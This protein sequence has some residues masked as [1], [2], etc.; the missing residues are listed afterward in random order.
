MEPNIIR[1]DE[2]VG[3]LMAHRY[4]IMLDYVSKNHCDNILEI[5]TNTGHTA[6]ELIKHSLNKQVNYH[7]IDLFAEGWTDDIERNE[8]SI[9][10]DSKKDV[11]CWL[12][13]CSENVFLHQGT[14]KEKHKEI[15][16]LKIKF[17]LIFIDGGHSY[18][19]VRDDFFMYLPLLKENGVIFFDDYTTEFSFPPSNKIPFGVKPFIDDLIRFGQYDI[20]IV[21]DYVDEYRGHLY[22]IV[23]VKKTKSLE[24]ITLTTSNNTKLLNDFFLPTLPKD[25][26]DVIIYNVN[27]LNLEKNNW[28]MYTENIDNNNFEILGRF[29]T[30]MN[31]K[32]HFQRKYIH[33]N[34]GKKIMF[35]D[36]DVIFFNPFK[37]EILSYLDEYD[38]VLQDNNLDYNGGVWAMNCNQN[39]LNFF[40]ELCSEIFMNY[41][42]WSIDKDYNSD[43]GEQAI[44]NTILKKYIKE[45][46]LKVQKLPIKYYANHIDSHR[47]P[48]KIP[49]DCIL[50]HA[51]NTSNL[52]EKY[53]LL[54]QAKQILNK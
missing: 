46:K 31:K 1:T 27:N 36:S 19:T 8:L 38:M 9:K 51:T 28:T 32:T 4:R 22:R 33:D 41:K 34:F 15:E 47:F 54:E 21:N 53:K 40:N 26:T 49:N 25:I 18:S 20:E 42:S 2:F 52:T 6:F 29:L 17:D 37:N 11:E 50:F 24:I 10:P 44:I 30:L 23:R 3:H 43:Y 14:S 12:K 48:H 35:I 5:G 39:V 45:N 7:G 13:F 16:K